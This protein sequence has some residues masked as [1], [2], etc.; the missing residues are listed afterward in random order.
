[1]APGDE[2]SPPKL[3]KHTFEQAALL[4]TGQAWIGSQ[5][6]KELLELLFPKPKLQADETERKKEGPELA[7][8]RNRTESEQ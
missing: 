7:A 8:P 3:R 2:Y 4:L 5:A 6:A 1:M